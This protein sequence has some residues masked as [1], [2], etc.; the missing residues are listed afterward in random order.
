MNGYTLD[1]DSLAAL[2]EQLRRAQALSGAGI[3]AA[4][5]TGNRLPTG[6][7]L[8][9]LGQSEAEQARQALQR[10]PEVQLRQLT[11]SQ[12]QSQQARELAQREKQLE[13]QQR[14][15]LGQLGL[16]GK[17][18]G[19]KEK[20][21]AL[22]A[23]LATQK[24]ERE[25]WSAIADPVTG[26][27]VG[28]NKRT[29]E[30]R[31]LSSGGAGVAPEPFPQGPLQ[32]PT[33]PTGP[34]MVPTAPAGPLTVPGVPSGMPAVPS[35]MLPAVPKGPVAELAEVEQLTAQ[36]PT[37]PPMKL[38]DAQS[39]AYDA[40]VKL[41]D[42]LPTLSRD[43][44]KGARGRLEAWSSGTER[45]MPTYFIPREFTT[46]EGQRYFAAARLAIAALLRK[47]SGAAITEDEWKTLG[48]EYVPMPYDTD[49]VAGDK[50]RR[51]N[52]YIDTSIAQAGASAA[53]YLRPIA[54]GTR[55]L[56]RKEVERKRDPYSAYR[57]Q[58]APGEILVVRKIG[59]EEV[60]GGIPANEFDSATDRKLE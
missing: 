6:Q 34:L 5:L 11:L 39:K 28:Y 36:W 4:T 47:E 43:R 18:L 16:Q 29:G 32:V 17:E 10:L 59:G 3:L 21:L 7:A 51:L 19:L 55:N 22:Q 42:V 57:S 50:I 49:V 54:E 45:G 13:Q 33:A 41:I 15:Q 31:I 37:P 44:P 1:M 38:N 14:Y 30:S 24:G 27:I 20:Q 35:A 48:P 60:I 52:R 26:A 40:S 58:L 25:D 2:R 46:P 12:Q 53:G 23:F 56:I 9:Q 8:A